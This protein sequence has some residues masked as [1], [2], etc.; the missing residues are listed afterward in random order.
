VLDGPDNGISR[1]DV[2]A[3][4]ASGWVRTTF[5]LETGSQRVNDSMEKGTTIEGMSRFVR[6]AH[7]AGVSV[8]TTA[9]LGFPG[10]EAADIDRTVTFLRDHQRHLDRV[11]L[12]RFKAIPGTRFEAAYRR[13]PERFADLTGF[14]WN[15]RYAR[16]AYTYAQAR[17]STYRRSKAEMLRLVHQINRKPLRAGAETFDGLM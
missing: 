13:H 14:H 8:R 11:R 4:R 3:A 6:D 12:S 15:Y 17:R 7:E 10:E 1:Y 5:G 2:A 16:A 9:M